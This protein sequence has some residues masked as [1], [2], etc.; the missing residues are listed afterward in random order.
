MALEDG[1]TSEGGKKKGN[2]A[3]DNLCFIR[4]I[5]TAN[6]SLVSRLSLL[7][8]ARSLNIHQSLNLTPKDSDK[9]PDMS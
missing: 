8:S 3:P 9:I 5:A 7:I 2:D 6:P 1:G 4:C